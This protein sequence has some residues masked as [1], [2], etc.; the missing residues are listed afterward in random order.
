MLKFRNSRFPERDKRNREAEQVSQSLVKGPNLDD[1]QEKSRSG[2]ALLLYG[3]GG[4]RC[5][6]WRHIWLPLAESLQ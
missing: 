4:M 2:A 3:D 6:M 5:P 1:L